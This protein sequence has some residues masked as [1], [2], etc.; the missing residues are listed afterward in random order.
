MSIRHLGMRAGACAGQHS[1]QGRQAWLQLDRVV[2][3]GR[4]V[5][6]EKRCNHG[7]AG[8]K[9][10]AA[11][12]RAVDV[13]VDL[14]AAEWRP[15]NA[16]WAGSGMSSNS[17]AWFHLPQMKAG[18]SRGG[19]RADWRGFVGLTA[20]AVSPRRGTNHPTRSTT[21]ATWTK[22]V[23]CGMLVMQERGSRWPQARRQA[24]STL[25]VRRWSASDA[26]EDGGIDCGPMSSA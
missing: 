9:D 24:E 12:L 22:Q 7:A 13:W 10:A 23:A 14:I 16:D 25:P 26:G 19:R 11:H 2:C 8:K 18:Q 21:A 4:I 6:K 1:N 3:S 20:V 5:S 17:H 15:S